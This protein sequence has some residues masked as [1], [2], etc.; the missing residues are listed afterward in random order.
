M[1]G[2]CKFSCSFTAHEGSGAHSDGQ[3]PLVSFADQVK[4]LELLLAGIRT[5]YERRLGAL[6]EGIR[7][8]PKGNEHA[9][10]VEGCQLGLKVVCG[11]IAAIYDPMAAQ[12]ALLAPCTSTER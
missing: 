2:T 10:R 8:K 6:L 11:G 5:R 1:S 4:G 12:A 7:D 3:E 9:K